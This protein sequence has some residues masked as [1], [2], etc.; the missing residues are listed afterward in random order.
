MRVGDESNRSLGHVMR[1]SREDYRALCS[2]DLEVDTTLGC[3]NLSKIP[4]FFKK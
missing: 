2:Y 4:Q 1:K 3:K